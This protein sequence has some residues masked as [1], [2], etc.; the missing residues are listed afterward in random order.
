MKWKILINENLSQ[1]DNNILEDE[2][3]ASIT[4]INSLNFI[5]KIEEE[6]IKKLK[7]NDQNICDL[8]KIIYLITGEKFEDIPNE[9]LFENLYQ[10]ILPKLKISSISNIFYL[11]SENLFINHI[12]KELSIPEENIYRIIEILKENKNLYDIK[13]IKTISVGFSFIIFILKEIVNYIS[14]M[15]SKGILF[16]KIRVFQKK[17]M[18]DI[19]MKNNCIR[20]LQD[21]S[22]RNSKQIE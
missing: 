14:L 1:N 21:Y 9:N 20:V 7:T 10:K 11:L 15:T 17:M 6:K 4:A 3:S 5:T 8:M 19:A 12:C 16:H 2:F 22:H 13:H 18:I